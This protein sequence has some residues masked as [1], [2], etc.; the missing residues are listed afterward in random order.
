MIADWLEK[1]YD[2]D[3]LLSGVVYLHK[4][5]DNRMDGASMKSLR[6][7]R[8]LCG[9]SNLHNVVLGTTMWANV[10]DA[11]GAR[12]E[13]E[14]RD[15][16]WKDMI[17][18]GSTMCRISTNA[19]DAKILIESFLP[20]KPFVAQLQQELK[21]GKLLCQT[22]AAAALRDEMDKL[23]KRYEKELQNTREEME[24]ANRKRK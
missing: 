6:L 18:Q 19:D 3:S 20:K 11:T 21:S 9:E 10:D 5:S 14:L 15:I 7:F 12:R 22:E 13:G 8:K 23:T 16:Y 17:A 24:K 2:E 4:I 1:T